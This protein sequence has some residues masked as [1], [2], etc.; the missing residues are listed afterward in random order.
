MS[1]ALPE[2]PS[3]AQ[4]ARATLDLAQRF[5][6]GE[7]AIVKLAAIEE[8]LDA[9]MARLPTLDPAVPW[10]ALHAIRKVMR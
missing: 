2:P 4:I 5:H 10:D 7:E 6:D 3:E 1:E 8:I 9:L